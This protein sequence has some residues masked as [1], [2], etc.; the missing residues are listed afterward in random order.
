MPLFNWSN[1]N[2]VDL[3]RPYVYF[4]KVTS[5]KEEYRYVGK[6]SSPSR[7]GAYEKNV[8]RVL[9]G[10]TKRRPIMRDG[11]P[12]GESNRK[13]RYVHLILAVAVKRGWKIEHYP[14]CNVTKEK[15]NELETQK[16][17]E[18]DCNMNGQQTWFIEEFNVLSK[19]VR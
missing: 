6:G 9:A 15:Q 17:K 18:L 16:K 4:I 13:F 3:E 7:M 2:K 19:K 8:E 10:R 12:Q 11:R 14:I 5:K 1:P